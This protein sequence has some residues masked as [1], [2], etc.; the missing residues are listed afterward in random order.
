MIVIVGSSNAVNLADGLDG[1]ATGCMIMVCV[2]FSVLTYISGHINF[3]K[4]LLIPYIEGSG[5]LSIFCA[6]ILGACMGFLWF[7]CYPASVFM[8]D[9]GSLTL[10]GTIGAISVFVKKECRNGA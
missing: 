10:G 4:Y 5:E 1:L 2:A 6:G 9:I 7:N 3:S 8:G